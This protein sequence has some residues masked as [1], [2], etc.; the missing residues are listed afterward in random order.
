MRSNAVAGGVGA[1]RLVAGGRHAGLEP[2]RRKGACD[3]QWDQNGLDHVQ[4]DRDGAEQHEELPEVHELAV[5]ACQPLAHPIG[6]PLQVFE[7][8]AFFELDEWR[9]RRACQHAP[10]D[11]IGALV[12]QVVPDQVLEAPIEL[13]QGTGYHVHRQPEEDG[14]AAGGAAAPG[15]SEPVDG[16]A[17]RGHE[18]AQAR[19]ANEEDDDHAERCQRVR[20]PELFE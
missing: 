4:G 2:D 3:Q 9:R 5:H 7:E 11:A 13:P 20:R 18:Q 16:A 12:A 8:G 19:V 15:S 14:M 6:R 1:L 17:H 10:L